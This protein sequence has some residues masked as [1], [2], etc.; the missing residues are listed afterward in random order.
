MTFAQEKSYV[1][2]I[3]NSLESLSINDQLEKIKNIPY[4]SITSNISTSELLLNQGVEIAE[5]LNDSISL[6]DVYQKLST[7]YAFKDKRDK[8]IE[9][10]LKS[11]SIYEKLGEI[12][13][14][15]VAYGD[16][17]YTIKYEN[18]DKAFT[19]MRKSIKLLEQINNNKVNHIYDNYGSLLLIN[20]INDSAIYYHKKALTISKK[21]QDS[22]SLGYNYAHLSTAYSVINKHTIAKKYIDSSTIIRREINDIYGL[23][24]NYTHTADINFNE[25][26]FNEAI[27]NYKSSAALA[28]ENKYQHLEKYCY[29]FIAKCYTEI[30][31]YKNAYKYN[32]EF[33]S[34]KDSVLNEQTNKKIAELEVEFETEKKEKEIAVQKEEILEQELEIKNKNLFNIALG[35]GLLLISLLSV[36]IYKYQKNKRS[37]LRTQ[38]ALKYDLAKSQTQNKLQEQRLRISRDL[39]DNIGSQL[40]FI[41]SSIDNLKFL[42]KSSDNKLKSKLSDINNF[43]ATT[44]SQLRDTI[45]AMNKNEISYDDFY[46][47]LLT[48][49]EKAKLVKDDIQFNFSSSIN[50]TPTFSSVEGINIFRVIQESINNAIKYAEASKI[51]I[52]LS[53]NNKV[54]EITVADN[55]KGFDINDIEF[56]NGLNNIQHR[57]TEINA[58]FDIVSK[59]TKG[60]KIQFSIPKNT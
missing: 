46:G 57:M 42:T 13:K 28:K 26:K 33:Q 43:A 56:G 34:L 52:K 44:I 16:L 21:Q 10:S 49:I 15:G 39:H 18:V 1:D 48:F 20:K 14:A 59:P 50:S 51:D 24:V 32:L 5:E 8:K 7:L 27:S 25:K 31:D 19:Y 37:Q 9:Y 29:E 3:K 45:W 60:T 55:G 41:I 58:N 54:I 30:N 22:I 53:E 36:G 6:A 12:E 23:A 4:S 2:S 38:L 35:S 11:I 47:R 40:T 17:G